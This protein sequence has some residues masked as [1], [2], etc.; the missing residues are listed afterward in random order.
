ML[1]TSIDKTAPIS[2]LKEL[3]AVQ[4]ACLFVNDEKEIQISLGDDLNRQNT[5]K[6]ILIF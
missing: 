5:I 2:S 1:A 6:N 4:F 3:R